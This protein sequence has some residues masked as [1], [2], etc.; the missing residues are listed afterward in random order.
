MDLIDVHSL[1]DFGLEGGNRK[2]FLVTRQVDRESSENSVENCQTDQE[3]TDAL[4]VGFVKRSLSFDHASQFQ[5]CGG[6]L[7][8]LW[9]FVDTSHTLISYVEHKADDLWC[10]GENGSSLNHVVMVKLSCS[11]VFI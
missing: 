10:L 9:I 7:G 1:H 5:V 3:Q 4:L 6:L 8:L 11:R 2:D